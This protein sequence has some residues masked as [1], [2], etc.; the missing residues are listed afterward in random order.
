MSI[1]SEHLQ[2]LFSDLDFLA[3]AKE[4]QK[5]C[6]YSRT[7]VDSGS[8]Y[9]TIYRSFKG[10]CQDT[11]GG[12]EIAKICKNALETY[13]R[14]RET[15]MGKLLL[16]KIIGAKLG[17]K[18]ISFTYSQL[19]KMSA[20]RSINNSGIIILDMVIPEEKPDEVISK[21]SVEKK[22]NPIPIIGSGSRPKINFLSRSPNDDFNGESMVTNTSISPDESIDGGIMEDI[23]IE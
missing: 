22:T 6:F 8:W 15:E 3:D 19:N 4:G 20:V 5:P 2:N 1:P 21:K 13:D 7:Y 12:G 23:D 14:I 10:E 11:I 9:G 18:R 17:L 16:T